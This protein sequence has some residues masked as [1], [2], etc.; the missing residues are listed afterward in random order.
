V[1]GGKKGEKKSKKSSKSEGGKK[2]KK[3]P[4]LVEPHFES[5]DMG[6]GGGGGG[7][8]TRMLIE[9]FYCRVLQRPPEN[10]RAIAGWVDY[11]KSN[12]VKDMVRAGI[13]GD[14]FKITFVDGKSDEAL[15]RT[16][17]DVLLARPADTGGLATWT[18]E[19]GL[20]GWEN[21]VNRFLATDEYN[22]K[23]GDDAVPGG[24]RAGCGS[25]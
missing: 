14:E 24:G 18:T 19:I 3:G 7:G 5:D 16:L 1:K 20:F 4:K 8:S 12:T 13:L 21:V 10:D 9:Q 17:Y 15:A 25:Q 22:N 6:N 2:A 23:F 11:L